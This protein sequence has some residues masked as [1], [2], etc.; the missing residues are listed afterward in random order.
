MSSS[1]QNFEIFISYSR[2]D[3]KPQK[4]GDPFGWVT[5]LRDEILADHRRFSTEPL[6]IFFDTSEIRDMDDWRHRVLGALRHSRIL[7][8]CLSPNYFQSKPCRWE[9]DEYV[10]RQV[11]QL[12]G[13]DSFA[14]VYFTEVPGVSEQDMAE[15]WYQLLRRTNYTDLRPWYPLGVE[16]LREEAVQQKLKELG[17]SLWERIKRAREAT[18]V[19]GNLRRVN[20]HFVGRRS[21]LRMLH[22]SAGCGA[23]GVVTVVHGLGG[24]GKT[25]L[26]TA[27]AHGWA[28]SYPGGLWTIGAEQKT[29]MLPLLGDLCADL[30]IPLSAG[31][32]ETADQRGR[33]ALAE[34]KRRVD[35]IRS[36]DAGKAVACLL[37]LDNVSEPALLAEPQLAQLPREDWLHVIA[38]SRLGQDTMAASKRRSLAFVTV[39]ALAEDDAVQ[40]M[41][42]HQPDARWP[43]D[44]AKVDAAAALEIVRESGGFA[45]AVESIA[46]YLGLHPEIR[47]SDYLARLR[48][49]GL[50]SVDELMDADVIAQMHHREKQLHVVLE[51]TL[52][53]LK[54]SERAVLAYAAL[55]PPE[56]VPWMWLKLLLGKDDPEAL[57]TRPGY[58]DPW[59]A[60]RRR[61]EGLRLLTSGDHPD[62]ARMHRMDS[63]HVRKGLGEDGVKAKRSSLDDFLHEF[64]LWFRD[65]AEHSPDLPV[66]F[67]RPV[68]DI[69]L[70]L[71]QTGTD[72]RFGEDAGIVGALELQMG[73]MDRALIFLRLSSKIIEREFNINP[74]SESAGV[75]FASSLNN[76]ADYLARRGQPGDTEQALAH[77]QRSLKVEEAVLTANPKNAEARWNICEGLIKLADF[78]VSLGRPGDAERALEYYERSLRER[79]AIL[80]MDPQNASAGR[81]VFLSL[82]KLAD[83]LARWGQPG[84]SERAFGFYHRSYTLT[85]QLLEANPQSALAARDASIAREKLA[86]FL[87][88][89]G[90]AG[91]AEW[92]AGCY[93]HNLELRQTLV[94]ANP[95]NTQAIRDIS[96]SLLK[97]ANC[98]VQRGMPG[99]A[100]RALEYVQTGFEGER[101]FVSG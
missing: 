100:D 38:T 85:N 83:Y 75:D 63:A 66:H 4:P 11:H 5:A 46:I 1:G 39:D 70:H 7:L 52:T 99:D 82:E 53:R 59:P 76:L 22:E 26:A 64:C 88:A 54:P 2:A 89:R 90:N 23:I 35:E 43:A 17:N 16:A 74:N 9:F 47:P 32:E 8:V 58:P 6:R 79:E 51:Q 96:L 28:D 3:N 27:Y 94:G 19:P 10:G 78:L 40:L 41:E 34:L 42:E 86:D 45:L 44:S 20:P 60:V 95:A 65:N 69:I 72:L 48:A 29:E 97:L 56:V 24:Q 93:E 57:A 14:Q 73:R 49:E 30:G 13:Q 31:T 37:F 84:D 33:R 80:G 55:L 36:R 71:G 21:E 92:A 91:D 68:Q 15:G 67:L 61:L 77:Y 12:M 81:N 87:L 62:I 101:R 18:S 98:L 25:E 50:P